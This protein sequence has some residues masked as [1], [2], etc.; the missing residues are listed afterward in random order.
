MNQKE[1]QIQI[2]NMPTETSK[3]EELSKSSSSDFSPVCQIR[4]LAAENKLIQAPS[5]PSI[6]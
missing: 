6:R 5:I 3:L 2:E 1:V 4:D